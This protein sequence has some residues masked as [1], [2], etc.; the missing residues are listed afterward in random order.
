MLNF[1]KQHPIRFVYNKICLVL[2]SHYADNFF[3]YISKI[4]QDRP[5]FDLDNNYYKSRLC[6]CSSAQHVT[7]PFVTQ[8][9]CIQADTYE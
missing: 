8:I 7:K 6:S 4:D 3:T 1:D 2:H 5:L 9:H